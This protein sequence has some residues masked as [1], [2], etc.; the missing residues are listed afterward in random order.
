MTALL[1]D[2]DTSSERIGSNP[3]LLLMGPGSFQR[4]TLE[5]DAPDCDEIL[6]ESIS[7]SV[8]S[9]DVSYFEGNLVP[10]SYPVVP[11][12]EYCGRVVESGRNVKSVAKGDIVTYFGQSDFGGLAK[13]RKIRPV[14]PGEYKKKPF[15]TH[16]YFFDDQHAA[17][18]SHS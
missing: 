17:R 5:L 18:G 7:V 4:G 13:Y 9:T 16:R 8:C 6:L 10:D 12:H 3:A 14:F 2:Y 1:E 11:G 15:E